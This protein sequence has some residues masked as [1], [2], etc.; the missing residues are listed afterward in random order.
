[1]IVLDNS[2]LSPKRSYFYANLVHI[3]ELK[4]ESQLHLVV[5][6]QAAEKSFEIPRVE[7]D[8]FCD[9]YCPCKVRHL[10]NCWSTL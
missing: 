5:L 9:D 2:P 10:E 4:L 7:G 6:E 3:G 8:T 1:M